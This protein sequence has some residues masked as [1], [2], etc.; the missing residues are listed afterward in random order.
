[1]NKKC[2]FTLIELLVAVT[3]FSTVSLVI[4]SVFSAGIKAWKRSGDISR[5]F[6][7]AGK[8]IH[9]VETDLSNAVPPT[10][11]GF[12]GKAD[13]LYFP[14]VLSFRDKKDKSTASLS[15]IWYR[16]KLPGGYK[17]GFYRTAL[18]FQMAFKKESPR[19]GISLEPITYISFEYPYLDE[20]SN[21]V[22]WKTEW[23][24]PDKL[25]KFVKIIYSTDDDSFKRTKQS[26]IINLP[27]GTLETWKEEDDDEEKRTTDF[28]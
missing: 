10:M 4:Y 25:P 23:K 1:M 27:L 5:Y 17:K 11:V 12:V 16:T 19:T 22:I 3:I 6:Q 14:A 24:E 7:D 18:P 28:F 9:L 15:K 20:E 26:R 13:E 8:S 2:G 21:T